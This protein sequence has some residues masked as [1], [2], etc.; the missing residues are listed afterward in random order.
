MNSMENMDTDVRGGEGLSQKRSSKRKKTATL[1][2]F[3]IL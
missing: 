3:H 2:K 1:L